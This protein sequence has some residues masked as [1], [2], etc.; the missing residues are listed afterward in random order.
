M[1]NKRNLKVALATATAT[2]YALV[3]YALNCTDIFGVGDKTTQIIT[4]ICSTIQTWGIPIILGCVLLY[5]LPFIPAKA[6]EGIKGAG[7]STAVCYILSVKDGAIII[8]I[9]DAFKRWFG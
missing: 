1:K 6:R 3:P 4:D 8:A 2:L 5:I 9:F 7:I